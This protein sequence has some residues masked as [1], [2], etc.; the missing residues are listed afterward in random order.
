[1]L[2]WGVPASISMRAANCVAGTSTLSPG[3]TRMSSIAIASGPALVVSYTE[4]SSKPGV[5]SVYCSLDAGDAGLVVGVSAGAAK[6]A[7]G[8]PLGI[9]AA[10]GGAAGP[11]A[12][13]MPA[14]N[15]SAPISAQTAKGNAIDAL[16]IRCSILSLPR[17]AAPR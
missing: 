14:E 15:I 7:G 9:T 16:V 17:L 8:P 12:H 5:T 3:A 13:A 10:A 2:S 6:G 4:R 11:A 1:M